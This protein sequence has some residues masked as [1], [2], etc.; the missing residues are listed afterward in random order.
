MDN[1]R[2]IIKTLRALRRAAKTNPEWVE[3]SIASMKDN[4]DPVVTHEILAAYAEFPDEFADQGIG[5]ARGVLER[6]SDTDQQLDDYAVTSALKVLDRFLSTDPVQVFETVGA[7][8]GNF[9]GDEDSDISFGRYPIGQAIGI[10]GKYLAMDPIG[11]LPDLLEIQ[12]ERNRQLWKKISPNHEYDGDELFGQ[13][14]TVVG[15]G[16]PQLSEDFLIR[17]AIVLPLLEHLKL[18]PSDLSR[19][20]SPLEDN[21]NV[22]SKRIAA[23]VLHGRVLVG[24]EKALDWMVKLI[25]SDETVDAV[26][27]IAMDA[28]RQIAHVEPAHSKRLIA[29]EPNSGTVAA[30]KLAAMLE[31]AQQDEETKAGLIAIVP[32]IPDHDLDQ[33]IAGISSLIPNDIDTVCDVL[34]EVIHSA[35]LASY[36]IIDATFQLLQGLVPVAFDRATPVIRHLIERHEE[37]SGRA[38]W[39]TLLEAVPS[40]VEGSELIK[41][42][43]DALTRS[44][45][46][47]DRQESAG[48]TKL[49]L[50][51]D[52]DTGLDVLERL[53]NDVDPVGDSRQVESAGHMGEEWFGPMIDSVRAAAAGALIDYAQSTNQGVQERSDE[54]ILN[55]ASDSSETVRAMALFGLSIMASRVT[56]PSEVMTVLESSNESGS[57]LVKDSSPLIRSRSWRIYDI[58][59]RR[60]L[61]DSDDLFDKAIAG[62][63]EEEVVAASAGRVMMRVAFFN[64]SPELVERWRLGIRKAS[65]D[66]RSQMAW[67]VQRLMDASDEAFELFKASMDDLAS[68]PSRAVRGNASLSLDKW[69]SRHPDSVLRW[70]CALARLE[71]TGDSLSDNHQVGF[72]IQKAFEQMVST[73][74]ELSVNLLNC[75]QDISDLYTLSR[76]ADSAAQISEDERQRAVPILEALLRR[77]VPEAQKTLE[78]WNASGAEE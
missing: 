44:A 55:L 78:L 69:V 47:L 7:F 2:T 58:L 39:R 41:E 9:F 18:H 3:N 37:L 11:R 16:P 28:A 61:I 54:L 62:L 53:S 38:S 10:L 29:A 70:G 64:R 26:R 19:L 71:S 74:P 35:N 67:E 68:D 25:G 60:R 21:Q 33:L 12:E 59:V 65:D 20:L 49:L 46:S 40:T 24:D 32:L 50:E 36:D 23:W 73:H 66:T 48:L 63:D 57:G 8:V 34:D 72:H 22:F 56:E 42:V 75:V 31:L 52:P 6:F 43:A 45:N 30:T 4:T 5:L 27:D 15:H 1:R 17:Q 76:I 14:W 77:G 51:T 13:G